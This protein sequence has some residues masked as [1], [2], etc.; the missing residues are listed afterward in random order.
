MKQRT[1]PIGHIL[2]SARASIEQAESARIK[3][4][5]LQQSFSLLQELHP[6]LFDVHTEAGRTFVN[7]F[8]QFLDIEKQ[9]IVDAFN[10]GA[11]DGLQLGEQYFN[12]VYKQ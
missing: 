9:Q 6:S 2:K 8:H 4:T 10:E 7:T 1:T 11:L 5:A 12:F 3:K